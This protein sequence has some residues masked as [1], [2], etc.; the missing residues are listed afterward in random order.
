MTLA[1]ALLPDGKSPV[2]VYAEVVRDLHGGGSGYRRRLRN[3]AD[4]AASVVAV[5][6]Y[7]CLCMRS[8]RQKDQGRKNEKLLQVE[9]SRA[10]SVRLLAQPEGVITLVLRRRLPFPSETSIFAEG[11]KGCIL[12]HFLGPRAF[13][14]QHLS[15]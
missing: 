10:L 6:Y 4:A 3:T 11:E 14:A 7:Y 9:A 12:H 8:S 1:A 2:S 15:H 13:L 5:S